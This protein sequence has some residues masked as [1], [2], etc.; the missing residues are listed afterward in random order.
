MCLLLDFIRKTVPIVLVLV[1][2][3]ES[4]FSARARHFVENMP[5]HDIGYP[6]L[7][8]REVFDLE[9]WKDFRKALNLYPE[10]LD[11]FPLK[12]FKELII[13]EQFQ[14]C[15]VGSRKTSSKREENLTSGC[16]AFYANTVANDPL[17]GA[18]VKMLLVLR[19]K[20]SKYLFAIIQLHAVDEA[21]DSY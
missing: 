21:D 18:R 15:L 4:A 14:R 6:A 11:E 9:I 3:E 5:F 16:A 19:T 1:G 10:H 7:I 12:Q 20:I 8:E 17:R 13:E 2:E